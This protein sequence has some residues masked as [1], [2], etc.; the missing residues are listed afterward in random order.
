MPQMFRRKV[1]HRD[2][3]A[4]FRKESG[5]PQQWLSNGGRLVF[6]YQSDSFK[7]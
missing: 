1:I 5:K 7:G 2:D 6:A 3:H 4:F